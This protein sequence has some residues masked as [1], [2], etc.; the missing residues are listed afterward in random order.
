[1]EKNIDSK[2]TKHS[3]L[4]MKINIPFFNENKFAP[5]SNFIELMDFQ[6]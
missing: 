4:M 2:D 6:D 3:F 1:M 5:Y